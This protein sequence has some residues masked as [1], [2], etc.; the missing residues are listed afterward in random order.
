VWR[1]LKKLEIELPHDPRHLIYSPNANSTLPIFQVRGQ[2]QRGSD[3]CTRTHSQRSWSW[4][5]TRA[6][7]LEDQ[8][9]GI[10]PV[11]GCGPYPETSS[12]N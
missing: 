3:T 2:A 11:G 9:L 6:S 12:I 1:F 4:V 5:G 7:G 10:L 8:D